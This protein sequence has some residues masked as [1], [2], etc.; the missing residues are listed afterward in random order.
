MIVSVIAL[1]F[2][3]KGVRADDY[4]AFH[5]VGL[6]SIRDSISMKEIRAYLSEIKKTR[7]TVA[8]V[9]SGGGAKGVSHIGVM[10]YLDSLKIPVDVVMGTSMGGLMG[11]LYALGYTPHQMDSLVR[12][13]DWDVALTDKVPRG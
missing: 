8:L 1:S 6:N 4:R 10:E 9:L 13:F 7:P 11:A 3:V 5:P 2:F 12:T